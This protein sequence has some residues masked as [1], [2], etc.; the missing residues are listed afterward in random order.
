MHG[1]S[2]AVRLPKE[3]RFK[4]KEV[5]VS[6]VGDKVILTPMGGA[7]AERIVVHESQAFPMPD[8]LSFEQAAGF[9]ITYCTSYHAL[10]QSAALQPGE[11]LLVLG[12]AGGVV[13]GYSAG[14]SWVWSTPTAYLFLGG[15]RSVMDPCAISAAKQMVSFRV[16]CG[17]MVSPMSS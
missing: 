3:F 16:G 15:I 4:G 8:S 12:A 5:R 14:G 9:P 2:Q 7:F 13:P 1:R 6:R 11:T 10:K 17:W